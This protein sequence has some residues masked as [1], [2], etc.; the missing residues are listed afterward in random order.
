MR[1]E[2]SPPTIAASVPIAF[3]PYFYWSPRS[4]TI[5]FHA[6]SADRRIRCA[7]TRTTL[8]D[9][10]GTLMP[11]SAKRLEE[12]FQQCREEIEEIAMKKIRASRFQPDGTVLIRT[13]DLTTV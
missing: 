3:E 5:T 9:R 6:C 1:H 10:A 12:C 13:L 2:G 4:Q 8:E 11:F 7:V